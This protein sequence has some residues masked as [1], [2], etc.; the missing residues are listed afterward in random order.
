MTQWVSTIENGWVNLDRA[1]HIE[2]LGNGR[3]RVWFGERAIVMPDYAIVE[4][5]MGGQLVPG[6]GEVVLVSVFAD[7]DEPPY[8]VRTE[9]VVAWRITPAERADYVLPVLIVRDME[10]INVRYA[11]RVSRGRLYN[12]MVDREWENDEE[13]IEWAR[14]DVAEDEARRQR[15]REAKA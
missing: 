1:D 14:A 12:P 2:L 13:F 4:D 8:F 11:V 9:P 10:S 3:Y 7:D 5:S 6:D 15:R